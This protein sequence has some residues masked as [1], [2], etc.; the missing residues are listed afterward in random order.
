MRQQYC[1]EKK[2]EDAAKSG[3]AGRKEK[4]RKFTETLSFLGKHVQGRKYVI[5]DNCILDIDSIS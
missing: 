4:K 2:D 3:D 5:S 1:K